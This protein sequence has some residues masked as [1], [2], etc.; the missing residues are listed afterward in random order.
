MQPEETGYDAME[1][2]P[3]PQ[4]NEDLTDRSIFVSVMIFLAFLTPFLV[5]FFAVQPS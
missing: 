4:I 1:K 2:D 3:S 5:W